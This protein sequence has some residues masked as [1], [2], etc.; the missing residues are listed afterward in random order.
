MAQLSGQNRVMDEAHIV[1]CRVSGSSVDVVDKEVLSL[2]D[3]SVGDV[4]RGYVVSAGSVGVLI[5]LVV[6]VVIVVVAAVIIIIIAAY[7]LELST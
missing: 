5:R 6:V 1:A 4:R 3:L 7:S 2:A